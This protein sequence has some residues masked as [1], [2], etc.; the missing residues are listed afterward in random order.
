MRVERG[1]EGREEERRGE[2]RGGEGRGG[3]RRRQ[4]Q[5]QDQVGDNKSC[6]V[7]KCIEGYRIASYRI[8]APDTTEISIYVVLFLHPT[9]L[10]AR[11]PTYLPGLKKH[12]GAWA[13]I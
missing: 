12:L 5:D 6:I 2:G 3:N 11:L 4:G 7:L 10:P 9:C 13:G 8:E 1:G